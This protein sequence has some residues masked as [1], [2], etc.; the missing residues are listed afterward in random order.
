[1][2]GL[3][4]DKSGHIFAGR[5]LG[6][7]ARLKYSIIRRIAISAATAAKRSFYPPVHPI[8]I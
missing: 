8:S 6:Y 4:Q 5:S 7:W 3:D 1:M 2:A